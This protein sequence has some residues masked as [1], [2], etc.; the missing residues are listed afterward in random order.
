MIINLGLPQIIYLTLVCLSLG[1]AIEQH[2]KPKEGI[3]NFWVTLIG[4][5][6]SILLLAWG[7]FFAK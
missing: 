6:I 7:G 4:T 3:N 1:I 2:G 5:V